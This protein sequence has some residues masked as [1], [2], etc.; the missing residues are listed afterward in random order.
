MRIPLDRQSPK[1]VYLQI[2]DRL[3]HLI[4]SGAM[5]PGERLPSIRMLAEN[6]QV[7]KLTVIEAYGVLEAD[8]LVSARQGAG[9]FV[10]S[11]SISAPT[12]EPTFAPVQD[13]I[14]PQQRTT[15]FFEVYADSM[16]AQTEKGVINLGCGFPRPP[17]SE[18]LRRIAR[19]A[20]AD[21]DTALFNYDLPQGRLV[22]R[23]QIAQ[24]LVWQ[25]GLQVSTDNIIITSGSKQGL[26]LMM[27]YHVQP[28]DWVIVESPT[29][30]GAIAVLE[31][32]GARVIG[33]P[34][35]ATG[36]NLDLLE[37]YLRSHRPKLIYTISTLHN[38]TG[39]TTSQAHRQRLLEL[40]E[41]YAC[42]I[43]EDNAYEGLNFEPV[44]APIKAIDRQDLVTYIGTF[45]KTL[46]PG[47]RVG[48]MVVT[49]K[50]YR[51]LVERKL[52]SDLHV[53]TVSQAIISEY[54]AS[55]HYR[56]HL[57]HLRTE[58]L[59]SR[60]AM[61]QALERYFPQEASWTVPNGG[62]FLWVHLPSQLPMAKIRQEAIAQKVVMSCG[63]LFFPDQKG[64]TA[65]RLNYS[66]TPAEI[67]RGISVLGQLLKKYL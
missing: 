24:M 41:Q 35:T 5:Q 62:L 7:N 60:N 49:G 44:P 55:G 17:E 11:S 58:N 38:P 8:G 30:H 26:S 64:Y 21:I 29:Y 50:H 6:A 63:S 42:P 53:S 46:M 31:N 59:Q 27:H 37:Q 52:L 13:V 23:K 48:Y 40:A 47:L 51:P 54:L 12:L 36:M 16:L 45:S 22:L 32:L 28:G 4:Q 9:Y 57:N 10:N 56:R 25:Q 14:I 61:L 2:R 43:L 39:I 66:S 20:I 34:M 67:E 33:I 3:R 15:S 19:R 65:M 1:P 18:D